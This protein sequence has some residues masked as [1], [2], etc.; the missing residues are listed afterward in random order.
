[1]RQRD[2]LLKWTVNKIYVMHQE[3]D[4]Y[5]L[6][7]AVLLRLELAIKHLPDR[8]FFFLGFNLTVRV[9]DD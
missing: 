4:L 9:N 1:M 7:H 6:S 3:V 5:S 2:S 8:R